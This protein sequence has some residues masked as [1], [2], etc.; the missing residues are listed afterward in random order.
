MPGNDI[1]LT[2]FLSSLQLDKTTF[3]QMD[4]HED[5]DCTFVSSYE[6]H[7]SRAWIIQIY[8]EERSLFN[9]KQHVN[10]TLRNQIM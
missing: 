1:A 5:E 8:D 4:L 9:T 2:F 3:T 7:Y 10:R 6:G